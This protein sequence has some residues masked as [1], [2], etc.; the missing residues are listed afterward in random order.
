MRLSRPLRFAFGYADLDLLPIML[1]Y[2]LLHKYVVRQD[3]L[4]SLGC[5]QT[6]EEKAN[7]AYSAY[8]LVVPVYYAY[9]VV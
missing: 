1:F 9:V 4:V 3:Y 8:Y 7:V 5:S 6:D 2:H